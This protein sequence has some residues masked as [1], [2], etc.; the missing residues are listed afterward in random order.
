M[1]A[2]NSERFDLRG[3]PSEQKANPMTD[4]LTADIL[5]TWRRRRA[6]TARRIRRRRC[7]AGA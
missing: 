3:L 2:L 4:I 1:R 7:T 5:D 6:G